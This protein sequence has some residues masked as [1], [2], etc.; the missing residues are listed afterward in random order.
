[1]HKIVSAL[2]LLKAKGNKTASRMALPLQAV[3][4][5]ALFPTVLMETTI[6]RSDPPNF[7]R[8]LMEDYLNALVEY[9]LPS[10]FLLC[11][12]LSF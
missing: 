2:D 7:F 6:M 8:F 5:Q 3:S 11:R 4:E 9:M 1:M 12:L 10:E